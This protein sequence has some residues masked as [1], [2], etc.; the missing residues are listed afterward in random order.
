M[1]R[2]FKK[3]GTIHCAEI[4]PQEVNKVLTAV[5]NRLRFAIRSYI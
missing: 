5:E 1:G 4:V 3:C 2:S